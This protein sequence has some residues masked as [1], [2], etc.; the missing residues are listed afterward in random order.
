MTL[1]FKPNVP[2]IGLSD[3]VH[4]ILDYLRALDLP[5]RVTSTTNHSLFSLRG[6]LSMHRKPGTNG[7]GLALDA[8]GPIAGD[9]LMGHA[10][11]FDAFRPVEHLLHELIY[12]G[13]QV[14]Y[15]IKR[16][17]RVAKY[18]QRSHHDH[19]HIAVPKGTILYRKELGAMGFP[20]AIDACWCPSG[21][22]VTVGSDGA[23]YNKGNSPFY[24]SMHDLL[25]NEK[26]GSG[27]FIS[28]EWVKDGYMIFRDD[29]A[30]YHFTP[31]VWATIQQRK[32]R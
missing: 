15:N 29:G 26:L 2:V 28:I 27:K 20:N 6:F 22:T 7:T 1:T 14:T 17:A 9:D 32:G 13:P 31:S 21:G 11:I 12:A 23:I 4:G 25:P 19:V 5:A 8:A 10:L 18:A 30:W 3:E 16:G 24:G